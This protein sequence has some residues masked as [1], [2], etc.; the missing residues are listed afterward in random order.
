MDLATKSGV[1]SSTSFLDKSINSVLMDSSAVISLP[2]FLPF[3]KEF[4]L[5]NFLFSLSFALS[6][7]SLIGLIIFL[8]RPRISRPF[9]I[10]RS[11]FC[12]I[13]C[14]Y[15]C[16]CCTSFLYTATSR[17]EYK[18]LAD[19]V[20]IMNVTTAAVIF[21]FLDVCNRSFNRFINAIPSGAFIGG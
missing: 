6:T 20:T 19:V 17:T 2:S 3:N 15:C 16:I 8:S 1:I 4:N 21:A 18:A 10:N 14:L 13:I 7:S 11:L 12:S 9:I 5:S